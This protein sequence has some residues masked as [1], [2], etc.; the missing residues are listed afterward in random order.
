[1]APVLATVSE[2][3][4]NTPKMCWGTL[5]AVLE[6]LKVTTMVLLLLD[7]VSEAAMLK[8]MGYDGVEKALSHFNEFNSQLI[9]TPNRHN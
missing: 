6:V 9:T 4:I 7:I 3:S 5:P 8:G 1:M 2:G